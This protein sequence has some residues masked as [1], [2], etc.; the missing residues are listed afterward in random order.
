MTAWK[1]ATIYCQEQAELFPLFC[2][3]SESTRRSPR[4][5]QERPR[6]SL[7]S[8]CECAIPGMEGVYGQIT[9][10]GLGDVI[11]FVLNAR[12]WHSA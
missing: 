6:R 1:A 11:Y 4:L 2:K 5:A 12:L 3:K 9:A 8:M 7:G 10:P